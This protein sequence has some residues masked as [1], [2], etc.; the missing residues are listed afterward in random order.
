[1]RIR[2]TMALALLMAGCPSETVAP[3]P[4][5]PVNWQ[6]LEPSGKRSAVLPG[7]TENESAAAG[8]YAR[9]FAAPAFAGLATQLDDDARFTFPGLGD[10]HGRDAIVRAHERLL[11]ALDQRRMRI[12]RVWRTRGEQTIE[13]ELTG[14][15]AREWMG[16]NA[17]EKSVTVKGV[18]LL[19]L[20]DDGTI[21]D[22]HLYFDLA[23]IKAQLGAGPATQGNVAGQA[24]VNPIDAESTSPP[25]I[26]DQ[27]LA[28]AE[29]NGVALA[30]ASL[31][32]L[33]GN[34][35]TAYLGAL[36][37]DVEIDTLER[38]QP[39]RGKGAATAYF[40]S[41]RKAIGQL[42]TTVTDAWGVGAFAIL[43]YT[44]A[45]EQLGPL[46]SISAQRDKT[47]VL[48]IVDIV[49]I[50]AEKIVHIWRYDN[51]TEIAV[52]PPS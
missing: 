51:P 6:S 34:N 21:T 41:M 24:A 35:L 37:D 48:H 26:F 3:P 5:P 4:A 9:T 42:D 22:L 18:A 45:G 1:M 52:T 46:G 13:W 11:G 14:I 39:S 36:A 8:T 32:A 40:K 49:E 31:D 12:R 38:T 15:Q 28:P 23:A 33:E 20:K 29:R 19:W 47:V 50:S 25:Q 10:I 16:I 2:F 30:K 7:P 17:S 27:D 44:I 43:E